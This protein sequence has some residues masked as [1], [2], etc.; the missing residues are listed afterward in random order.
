MPPVSA[1]ASPTSPK[2]MGATLVED[3]PQIEKMRCQRCSFEAKPYSRYC[4]SCGFNLDAANTGRL[5]TPPATASLRTQSE[6]PTAGLKAG[7]LGAD[8]APT[9]ID[10]HVYTPPGSEREIGASSSPT[11]IDAHL[12][13]SQGPENMTGDDSAPTLLDSYVF[14][15]AESEQI[16]GGNVK[17]ISKKV[18]DFLAGAKQRRSLTYGT[19]GSISNVE[20]AEE[21]EVAGGRATT[22]RPKRGSESLFDSSVSS[23]E[24]R[25]RS[26]RAAVQTI[27]IIGVLLMLAAILVGWWVYSRRPALV[28][29]PKQPEPVAEIPREPTPAPS[30]NPSSSVQPPEGMVYVP[31]GTFRMG[32]TGGDKFE[33]PPISVTLEPFFIDRTE[34]TNEEYQKFVSATGHRAPSN[35]KNGKFPK[36][37]GKFPVVNVSWEDA[38]EYAKWAEKRLPSEAEWEFAARGN[39]GRSYPWGKKWNSEY[40]NAGRRTKGRIVA[41]GSYLSGASP[42]GALDMC[43]NV[44][45]W[46]GD[47]MHSYAD[48]SKELAPGKVIRGGA[49]DVPRENATVTYRGVLPP[50]QTFDKTGFR[51]VREAKQ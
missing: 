12:F 41:V 51:C 21:E 1:P 11:L 45:E 49:Y 23:V 40:A 44:W 25:R 19:S 50:T 29:T 13:S 36:G 18:D 3:L 6:K 38:K 39:D 22:R 5:K 2:S 31:G 9:L 30:V 42:F 32:R 37:E 43:G 27:A 46:T 14:P 15:S 20:E 28:V 16:L 7:E 35:W 33:S 10:H 26:T 4:E 24:S 8:A 34:V 47:S 48:S 17:G